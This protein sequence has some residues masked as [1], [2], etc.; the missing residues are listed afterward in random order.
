M[1]RK[2]IVINKSELQNEINRLEKSTTFPTLSHLWK[3]LEETAWAR[4]Y[5]PKGLKSATLYVKAK[6]LGITTKTQPGKKGR[7]KG[8]K[9]TGVRTPRREKLKKFKENFQQMR[10]QFPKTYLPLVDAAENGS[11][12]AAVKLKCLDCSANQPKEV[13]MCNIESCPLFPFRPY[14]TLK[15]KEVVEEAIAA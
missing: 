1:A 11:M 15:V 2:E 7:S 8:E 6:S 5:T 4:N 9:V 12:K 13:K 3:A 14:Q 10:K